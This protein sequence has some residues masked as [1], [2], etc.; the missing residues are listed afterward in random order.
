MEDL[1]DN[2]RLPDYTKLPKYEI[3]ILKVRMIR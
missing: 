1:Y 2:S 3:Q